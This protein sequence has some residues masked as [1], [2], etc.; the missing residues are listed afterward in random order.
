[1]DKLKENFIRERFIQQK[2]VEVL[3]KP[4]CTSCKLNIGLEIC[5]KFKVKPIEIR[6]NIEECKYKIQR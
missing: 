6:S 1:M 2:E 4:Q 3:F 5:D